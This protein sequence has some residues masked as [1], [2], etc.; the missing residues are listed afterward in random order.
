M[1]FEIIFY[2]AGLIISFL[3]VFF[4]CK[5][6]K[7]FSKM[8]A[9][10][11]DNEKAKAIF[12]QIDEIIDSCVVATNQAFV[13]SLKRQN[14]FTSEAQKKAFTKTKDA[15]LALLPFDAAELI[16][17]KFNDIDTYLDNMIEKAVNLHK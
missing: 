10:R 17:T 6:L 11:S 5:F 2:I 13:E 8:L 9:E 14:L 3:L 4:V 15:I 1:N 12:A 7:A 16:E